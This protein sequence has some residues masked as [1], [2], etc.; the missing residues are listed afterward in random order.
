MCL[1][2]S[3][4]IG[5]I[6][7]QKHDYNIN[8]IHFLKIIL[9]VSPNIWS[10]CI[11]TQIAYR[12]TGEYRKHCNT[13]SVYK[14][15]ATY[16]HSDHNIFW[17]L[18]DRP[19]TSLWMEIKQRVWLHMCCLRGIYTHTRTYIKIQYPR[20]SSYKTQGWR[21]RS[22][23]WEPSMS[24]TKREVWTQK[25]EGTKWKGKRRCRVCV[26][27]EGMGW[28]GKLGV[29]LGNWWNWLDCVD[30]YVK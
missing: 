15:Q 17:I 3:I 11:V 28:P 1:D 14:Y 4:L 19:I 2:N 21:A 18:V 8:N 9:A 5:Q 12:L 30:D 10:H 23:K 26:Q 24:S 29:S 20:R 25:V 6:N 27:W 16:N 22:V 7:F 13:L